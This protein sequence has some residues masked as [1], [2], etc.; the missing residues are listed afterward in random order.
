MPCS[1][2]YCLSFLM[3][4]RN[5]I[6]GSS[7]VGDCHEKSCHM[8]VSRSPTILSWTFVMRLVKDVMI[9]TWRGKNSKIFMLEWYWSPHKSQKKKKSHRSLFETLYICT[10][11][12]CL[13]Y[14]TFELLV[15]LALHTT[16]ERFQVLSVT[17]LISLQCIRIR[18]LDAEIL[19]INLQ[20]LFSFGALHVSD[21]VSP[22]SGATLYKLYIA[23]GINRYVWPLCGYS[24]GTGISRLV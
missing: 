20:S 2:N 6:L 13:T 7:G 19:V 12:L 17:F 22:S 14:V 1:C 8:N 11:Y 5:L 3:L 23:I 16:S 21:F 10:I 18:Q 4:I 9:P 24:H 15:H